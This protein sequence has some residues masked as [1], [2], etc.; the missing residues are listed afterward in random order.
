MPGQELIELGSSGETKQ[1]AQCDPAEIPLPEF[2]ERQRFEHA[3]FDL[4][5][6]AE[7]AGEICGMRTVISVKA[8]EVLSSIFSSYH[9]ARVADIIRYWHQAERAR[10][11]RQRPVYVL[12]HSQHNFRQR[13][14]QADLD[15]IEDWTDRAARR[16]YE[17]AG[18][19]ARGR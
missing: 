9:A 1:P 18:L 10:D 19:R 6:A 7:A 12:N 13:T 14:T 17:G 5:A 11:M 16:M 2:V 3:A 15:E 8:A 4:A